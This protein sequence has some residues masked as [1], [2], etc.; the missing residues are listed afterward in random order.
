MQG[1]K[2][3]TEDYESLK[4]D[5]VMASSCSTLHVNSR[6]QPG[7][8]V[9]DVIELQ[10][11]RAEWKHSAAL[12]CPE[13]YSRLV[14]NR[15]NFHGKTEAGAGSGSG[16]TS[17]FASSVLS[18]AAA[19]L[20]SGSERWTFTAVTRPD[21]WSLSSQPQTSRFVMWRRSNCT[22]QDTEWFIWSITGVRWNI[23]QL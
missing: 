16:A 20:L 12:F 19:L 17:H 14:W 2:W 21:S 18:E 10:L 5:G 15:A 9:V 22:R 8:V 3:F 11:S 23:L 6:L 7:D 4:C 13:Y 1:N